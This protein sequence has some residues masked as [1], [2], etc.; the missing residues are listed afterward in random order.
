MSDRYSELFEKV[1]Q[2]SELEI[3]RIIQRR[4][5][6]LEQKQVRNS[7]SIRTLET[8]T[9]TLK[10]SVSPAEAEAEMRQLSRF[11]HIYQQNIDDLE[12]NMKEHLSMELTNSQ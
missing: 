3:E 7:C 1:C 5:T 9:D 4:L 11:D 2:E 12:E 10:L 6:R 8:F